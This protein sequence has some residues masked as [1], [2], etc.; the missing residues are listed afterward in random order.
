V[1]PHEYTTAFLHTRTC[2]YIC[3][4]E[5]LKCVGNTYVCITPECHVPSLLMTRLKTWCMQSGNQICIN[6]YKYVLHIHTAVW[7]IFIYVWSHSRTYCH[8]SWH[9]KRCGWCKIAI[10][11]VWICITYTYSCIGY[12]CISIT[13]HSP[14]L[15]LLLTSRKLRFM[16]R[17]EVGGWG[18]V[19]FSR[20]LMSPTPRRKWYLTTGRRFH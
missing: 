7:D 12:I 18:R 16:R 17:G 20:N 14:V 2:V 5:M 19:P 10:K 1:P 8:C 13:P 15:S 9:S 4:I 11:D 6:V 3:I